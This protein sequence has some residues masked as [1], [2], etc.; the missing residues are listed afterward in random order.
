MAPETVKPVPAT[1]AEVTVTAAAPVEDNVSVCVDGVFTFTL[2]NDRLEELR[3]KVST[4]ALS[5][6]PAVFVIPPA[7]A[8]MVTDCATLTADTVAVKLALVEPAL[9]VT[10][11]GTVTALLLLAKRTRR[12]LLSAA[13]LSV[14]V[15]L[16]VPAPDIVLVAHVSVLSPGTPLPVR[17][18]FFVAASVELDVMESWPETEPETVGSNCSVSVAL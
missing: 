6:S 8:D 7:L 9:T 18:T 12:P 3:P 16:S 10:E 11:D 15:Q 4:A 5:C 14:I 13:A 17:E 1:A 2:P